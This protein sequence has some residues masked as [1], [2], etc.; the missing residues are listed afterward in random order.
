MAIS[1]TIELP[2]GEEKTFTG[3]TQEDVENEIDLF[4]SQEYPEPESEEEYPI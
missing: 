3:E 1:V 2:D 4:F